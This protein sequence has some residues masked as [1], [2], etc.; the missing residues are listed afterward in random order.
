MKRTSDSG[1]REREDTR[2]LQQNKGIHVQSKMFFFFIIRFVA[3]Q[4]VLQSH[5]YSHFVFLHFNFDLSVIHLLCCASGF[6]RLSSFNPVVL[7]FNIFILFLFSVYCHII[8][9]LTPCCE[10]GDAIVKTGKY[11][12][13]VKTSYW[14]YGRS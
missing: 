14:L 13:K 5:F 1:R 10:I 3:F 2:D 4:T 6:R 7:P 9:N 8:F 11:L 12:M